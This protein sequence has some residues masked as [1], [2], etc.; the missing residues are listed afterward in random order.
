MDIIYLI[1]DIVTNLKYIGSKKNWKGEN[2][3]WGSPNCKN[4]KYKKYEI[5]QQ[6]KKDLIE[7]PETFIFDILESY[8]KIE[9][10]CLLEREL[11][12]QYKFNVVQSNEYINVGFAKKGFCGDNISIL[13]DVDK[14]I[15]IDKMKSSL[16]NT[17]NNLTQKER[18]EKY[19]RFGYKNGNYGNKWS[20]EKK[21]DFSK[22]QK[23]KYDK[24]S[25]DE[26][27]NLTNLKSNGL[28]QFIKSMSDS[29][30]HDFYAKYG[31]DNPFYNKKHSQK[32]KDLI[33]EKNKGKKPGNMVSIIIDDVIYESLY[34][35]S[36]IL[37]I[38]VT[39][40]LWRVNS[41]NKKFDNYK[42]NKK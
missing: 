23:E 6:W 40:I 34:E 36:R 21:L 9:H 42:Y 24:L 22:C 35:A 15:R 2:T 10:K 16:N 38:H 26:K 33:S 4:K 7:R 37:N 11:Y 17:I 18:Q 12:Y 1:T 39:T 5:Q 32:T 20:D 29:E 31:K 27:E 28:R 14:N 13:N 3:Y 25:D 41:K 19:G 30:R 8:E